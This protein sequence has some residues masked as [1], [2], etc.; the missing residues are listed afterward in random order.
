MYSVMILQDRK[1]CKGCI[2]KRCCYIY[3]HKLLFIPELVVMCEAIFADVSRKSQVRQQ[4]MLFCSMHFYW[5]CYGCDIRKCVIC[6]GS[7]TYAETGCSEVTA[8]TFLDLGSVV[9]EKIM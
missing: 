7:Y 9:V 1:H 4:E 5:F 2:R 8:G 3:I 6:D